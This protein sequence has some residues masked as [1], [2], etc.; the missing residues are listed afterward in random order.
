[1]AD[2]KSR[3]GKVAVYTDNAGANHMAL[4]VEDFDAQLT[5]VYVDVTGVRDTFGRQR[6]AVPH[7]PFYK[8]GDKRHYV[9]LLDDLDPNTVFLTAVVVAPVAGVTVGEVAQAQ[10][11]VQKPGR[12]QRRNRK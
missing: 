2:G 10:A 11:A 5:V 3:V 8:E 4:V 7:V 9:R 1:M 6:V 12:V